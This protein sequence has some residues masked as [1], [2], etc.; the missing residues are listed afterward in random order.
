MKSCADESL[1]KALYT[2]F[3]QERNRGTPLSD[4][5]LKEKA[6]WYQQQ[7]HPGDSSFSAS[8]GWLNRWKQR[9]GIRQFSI[10]G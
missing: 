8:E 10:Q 5:I 2:W 4:P 6:L 3:I 7:L 9:H 1:D